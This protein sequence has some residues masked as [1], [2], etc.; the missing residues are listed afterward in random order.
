MTN[1]FAERAER[2][3]SDAPLQAA[4]RKSRSG[5]VD[6]RRRAFTD[7]DHFDTLRD[8]AT[9]IRAHALAH[10]PKL[11]EQFETNVEKHA[12]QVHWARNGA[13][14]NEIIVRLCLAAG[15]RKVAK[16]KSMAS[17][18]TDLNRALEAMHLEVIETDLGEYILQLAR[19]RP[20]HIIAPA[21]HKSRADIEKLFDEHHGPRARETIADLV[22]EARERLREQFLGADV[23]ITGANWLIAE[24]GSVG[25]V[26]NEGNGDLS[27]TLPKVHIVLAGIEK[28]CATRADAATLMRVLAR[29][30]TGQPLTAYTTLH[31]GA[32]RAGDPDGPANFHVVLLDN[33]RS[34][35]IGGAFHDM[36]RC[37]RCGACLNHCPVYTAV[38]GHAYG[39]VYPGPMGSVLTPLLRGLP[40][41]HDLVQ[42]C[43]LNGRC[44]VVCPASIPLPTLLRELRERRHEAGLETRLERTSLR[45]WAWLAKRPRWYRRLTG[46][47]VRIGHWLQG[48][49]WIPDFLVRRWTRLR[50]LPPLPRRSFFNRRRAKP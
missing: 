9:R 27:A 40:A 45:A 50:T 19:E 2:A 38:G 6:K 20:S 1:G 5:F 34:Q 18:E 49:G 14:A 23:G 12:G 37:I 15:A 7:Y 32:K 36:L 13:E 22:D 42:A 16:G 44:E 26:T 43:T 30:A 46:L 10:L 39:D 48:R 11:L 21:V 8:E 28:V 35:T 31:T 25:L 41:G 3:L 24:T 33:G 29:S 47:D 4:L 17:E